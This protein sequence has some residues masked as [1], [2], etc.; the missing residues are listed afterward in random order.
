[1][2]QRRVMISESEKGHGEYEKGHGEYEKG[3]LRSL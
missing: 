3:K 1:V 2:N